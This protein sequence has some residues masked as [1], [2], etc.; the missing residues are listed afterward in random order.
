MG[1]VLSETVAMVSLSIAPVPSRL[2]RQILLLVRAFVY[3]DKSFHFTNRFLPLN[4]VTG[5][6]VAI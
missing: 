4:A 2:S 1:A 5:Y 3:T 6:P